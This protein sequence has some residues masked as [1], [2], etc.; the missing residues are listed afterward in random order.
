MRSA[1]GFG[2][3]LI[4]MPLLTLLVGIKTATPL[5]ALIATTIA[6]IIL[7]KNWR[8]VDIKAARRLI[9]ASLAG[10]PFGLV[11]LK[12]APEA[13]VT[14]LLGGILFLFGLYRLIRPQFP[15][16]RGPIWAYLFG[17]FAGILGGAYNTNGPLIV[18]YSSLRRW[19]PPEFRATLQGYFLP[20]GLL[21]IIGHGIAG[22]WTHQVISFYLYALPVI[23]LSIAVGGWLH[24]R[25]S[26]EFFQRLI[27]LFLVGMGITLIAA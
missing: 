2:D 13:I 4:A 12:T 20:T 21:I 8:K 25:L 14:K 22:L 15:P 1:L 26:S 23:L 3:A 7:I 19:Q 6:T 16:L 11:L 18:V 24:H 17:F 9:V 5:T 10:I 27:Y